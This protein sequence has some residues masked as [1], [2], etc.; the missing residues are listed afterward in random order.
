MG[1]EPRIVEW[2][3]ADPWPRMR[4]ILLVGP[5][6]LTLG[7]LVIAVSFLTH[8]PHAVRMHAAALGFGLVAG[9]AVFTMVG[10][11]RILREDLYLALRSDGLV[12]HSS[13]SE[14]LVPWDELR[15]ARWD[16]TRAELVLLPA[17]GEP[18]VLPWPFAGIGG[19]DLAARVG[20]VRRKA[21][22]KL[23]R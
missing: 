13:A 12:V 7:G 23:L 19:R 21:A 11:Q 17:A 3:R 20:A 2:Y 16:E 22:M 10:M 15:E 14:T 4:R 18:I 1:E 9:G 8:L 5:T 6:L